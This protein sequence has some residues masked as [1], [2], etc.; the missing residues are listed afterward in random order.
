M[1]T[2]LGSSF[3]VNGVR[4]KVLGADKFPID[5]VSPRYQK[6]LEFPVGKMVAVSFRGT[7]IPNITMKGGVTRLTQIEVMGL[8][9]DRPKHISEALLIGEAMRAYDLEEIL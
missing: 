4:F 9:Y 8:V 6:I 1:K 2:I 5:F 3:E 7:L